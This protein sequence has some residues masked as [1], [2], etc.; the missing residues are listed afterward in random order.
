MRKDKQSTNE[1]DAD[2]VDQSTEYYAKLGR[3][4]AR[5][6][7]EVAN[8]IIVNVL[9]ELDRVEQ[10]EAEHVVTPAVSTAR[11]RRTQLKGPAG[12]W[13]RLTPEERSVEMRRRLAIGRDKHK[14][15]KSP[16]FA[17]KM[18]KASKAVWANMTPAQKKARVRKIQAGRAAAKVLN[19][20][21]AAAPTVRMLMEAQA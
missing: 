8:D 16:E 2:T 9:R 17:A 20:H 12:Y 1:G 19:G 21:A 7:L 13:A 14:G 18:S 5:L 15:T 3:K 6:G 4:A 10:N 11:S